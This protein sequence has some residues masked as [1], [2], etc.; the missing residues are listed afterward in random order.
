MQLRQWRFSW[1]RQRELYLKSVLR[2]DRIAQRLNR[3]QI[4]IKLRLAPVYCDCFSGQAID[5][6][7]DVFKKFHTIVNLRNDFVHANIT[8]SM[9]SPV[10]SEDGF[11]F[12]LDRTLDKAFQ[13]KNILSFTPARVASMTTAIDEMIEVLLAS[14]KPKFRSEFRKVMKNSYIRVTIEDGEMIIE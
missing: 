8:Q 1:Q 13:G 7:S 4:D 9:S 3:E 14:M 11:E 10:V 12:V 2:D 5:H 6:T